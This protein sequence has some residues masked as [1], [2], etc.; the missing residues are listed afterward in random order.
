MF[1][2][3]FLVLVFCLLC[4]PASLSADTEVEKVDFPMNAPRAYTA[5]FELRGYCAGGYVLRAEFGY[6]SMLGRP[7]SKTVMKTGY[8][9]ENEYTYFYYDTNGISYSY[10]QAT[11]IR[12]VYYSGRTKVCPVNYD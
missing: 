4:V 10:N 8:V 2:K 9:T 11:N 3:L 12:T 6:I 7:Q 1:K 5:E